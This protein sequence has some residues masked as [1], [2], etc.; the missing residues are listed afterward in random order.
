MDHQHPHPPTRQFKGKALTVR[1]AP[2]GI[3]PVC[4][5]SV[6]LD[7]PLH[8]EHAGTTYVFCNPRCRERFVAE[9]ERF[10]K[11]P[12][13]RR[14]AEEAEAAALPAGTQWVCPMDPEVLSDHPGPCP[15]CG[16]AL[17]PKT[18]DLGDDRPDPEL[19]DMTGRLQVAAPLS[20]AVM[21]VSMG[22]MLFRGLGH[23][24]PHETRGLIEVLLA[25]PVV[26]WSGWPL[27]ERAAFSLRSR[28]LNMF[29]LIGLGVVVAF[30]FSLA[31]V[32]AP[33][34]FPPA[35]RDAHGGLPLYFEAAAVIV[36]LVLVGQV[37]ELR[38]RARTRDALRS[39]LGLAPKTARRVRPD[40][41]DEDVPLS[42]V[43][44]GDRLRVR[45]GEKL[46]VDGRVLEGQS[47]VDE[48]MLTGEP[49]PVEK[50]PGDALVGGTLNGRGAL[51][52]RAE[53]VG[54]ETLL[55][56]IVARVA[57]AQRSRAPIQGLAD[58]VAA[59]FVPAVILASALTFVG[60]AVLGPQPRLA[61]A[62][63]NAVSVL[64]IA[65]PCALGLATPMSI[66]VAMGR[67]ARAG[68]LF[69]NAEAL[70]TLAGVDTLALDKTGTLTLGRPA[71][72]WVQA[73]PGFA[74]DDVLCLAASLERSSEHPLAHA[75]VTAAAERGYTLR[76]PEGFASLPGLGVS[77]RVRGQ[78]VLVGSLRLL[79]SQGVDVAALQ[80]PA[81]RLSAEGQALLFVAVGG[82]AAGLLSVTDPLRPG[83]REALAQLRQAGLRLVMLTGDQ[84]ATAESVGRALGLDDVRAGLL[85]ADK[86]AAVAE[87]SAGGR[88]VA[89]AGDGV[90]D[91]VALARAR[92]GIAMGTGTDVAIES[93]GVTLVKGDLHGLLRARRLSAATVRNIRQNLF[94]AFVYNALG[95]PL[96]AGLLYPFTGLLLSPMVAAAAMSVSSVSV[97]TNALRLR[98]ARLD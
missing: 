39:L 75:V 64:I 50:G 87:L 30:G 88:R 1:E 62:L 45:P 4:G 81:A 28:H 92:V 54:R 33:G 19:A 42:H 24:V 5:M 66:M 72:A 73:L 84:R 70:E 68:V 15:K 79:E 46:P 93:A 38:A 58:R 36:A 26:L 61:H 29:T 12:E 53:R 32:L 55:M 94:F 8:H 97:I 90:N 2:T 49:L 43:H 76:E 7:S 37:L 10:L 22:P 86:A 13:E 20:V 41:S 89:M 31:A 23:A 59:W 63:V 27:L 98:R 34:I 40:G 56:Q 52:M 16:M 82:R 78:A 21:A 95:I 57:E 83:A 91:A 11:P 77:G 14:A 25:A 35:F 60:W 96:A 65:C 44:V 85:P 6:P 18:P 3:D 67:G 17:E 74:E 51:V 69:R 80:E 9:P 48:S 47:S 71:L